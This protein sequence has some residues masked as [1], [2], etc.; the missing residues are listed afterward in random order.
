MTETALKE[1]KETDN[2]DI[3]ASQVIQ[4]SKTAND[5]NFPVGSFLIPA[6]IRPHVMAYYNFARTA[7]DI[8]DS[9]ELT[10]DEK[11]SH[12]DALEAV[13]LGE[14][15]ADDTTIS[16]QCLKKS[17]EITKITPVHATD[18]LIAFR[19]DARGF[20]YDTFFELMNY[21]KHSAAPVGRY[22]LDLHDEAKE[23]YWPSDMLCSALQIINHIQDAKKDKQELS[24]TYLPLDFFKAQGIDYKE[25]DKDKESEPFNKV[26]NQLIEHT[27]GLL[28]ESSTLP[29]IIM[30][31]GLR[32]EVCVIKNLA[33]RLLE[34][35][36]KNDILA[37][38]IELA[39]TD[40]LFGTLQGMGQ[41]LCRGKIT[42]NQ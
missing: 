42:C 18:L 20:T 29:H 36:E 19:Q 5:E 16:A 15:E 13:L 1:Q 40:W 6:K 25:L 9:N 39:K 34:K 38:H 41:G 33:W 24:R 23:T 14:K 10:A 27:K 3:P 12:L 7:D 28:R 35:I 30:S 4:V 32:M 26:I 2:N 17:L 21:C 11:L 8:A 22:M 31:R 37:Q